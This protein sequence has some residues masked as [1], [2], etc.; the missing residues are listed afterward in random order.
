MEYLVS[1][2]VFLTMKRK[3]YFDFIKSL[4]DTDKFN[5]MDYNQK[6]IMLDQYLKNLDNQQS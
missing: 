6:N 2:D 1:D 4:K 3:A 5:E